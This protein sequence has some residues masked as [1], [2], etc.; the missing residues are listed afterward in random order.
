MRYH[1]C[2]ITNRGHECLPYAL[3]PALQWQAQAFCEAG[4]MRKA[5]TTLLMRSKGLMEAPRKCCI[6]VRCKTDFVS[7]G[8]NQ[9]G[10]LKTAQVEPHYCCGATHSASDKPAHGRKS[11]ASAEP[12]QP[13]Q[14][15]KNQKH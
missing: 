5:A 15:P 13:P 4:F 6:V 8:V 7:A 10:G 2:S 14:D 11:F 1:R 3:Q 12:A 9:I